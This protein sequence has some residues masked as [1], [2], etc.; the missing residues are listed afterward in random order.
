MIVVWVQTPMDR[1]MM[2]CQWMN[3][4]RKFM[5][6]QRM[7]LDQVGI[8][9]HSEMERTSNE[10]FKERRKKRRSLWVETSW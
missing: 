6:Y 5:F 2:T 1:V 9:K 10:M 3:W 4:K 7:V 8:K